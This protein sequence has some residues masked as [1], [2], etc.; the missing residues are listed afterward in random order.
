MDRTFFSSMRLTTCFLQAPADGGFSPPRPPSHS[1]HANTPSTLSTSPGESR[2]WSTVR[3]GAQGA[4]DE[5]PSLKRARTGGGLQP[6]PVPPPSGFSLPQGE[7]D[8]Q[9]PRGSTNVESAGGS[10]KGAHGHARRISRS[11]EGNGSPAHKKASENAGEMLGW[12]IW[13]PSR[14][15]NML[16]LV[17][18]SSFCGASV[19]RRQKA[20]TLPAN[21]ASPYVPLL[22]TA[23]PL[24]I[25]PI[26]MDAAGTHRPFDQPGQEWHQPDLSKR[27][28]KPMAST[29]SNPPTGSEGAFA[30]PQA[31]VSLAQRAEFSPPSGGRSG[32]GGG[33]VA[34]SGASKTIQ[35]Y[36]FK[37]PNSTAVQNLAA[38]YG[39]SEPA[40]QT[41][42]AS[43]LPKEVDLSGADG[44][45]CRGEANIAQPI[46][47][48]SRSASTGTGGT[49]G[50]SGGRSLQNRFSHAAQAAEDQGACQAQRGQMQAQRQGQALG[51]AGDGGGTASGANDVRARSERDS[52]EKLHERLGEA[53]LLDAQLRKELAR[54]N[55]ERA[56]METMVS[57]AVC[58]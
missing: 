33:Q 11:A 2:D 57:S 22:V 47:R 45:S 15:I 28:V 56:S 40:A 7:R 10:T 27:S 1:Q 4:G 49:G 41:R 52:V 43:G 50:E 32:K 14:C 20:H 34:P 8:H 58:D 21:K 5:V 3:Q 12:L 42:A 51:P 55:L 37:P 48:I 53:K 44:D 6:P 13:T 23:H 18:I 16:M 26:L 9:A 24:P 36:F 31:A 30:Q 54:A 25:P 39:T 38:S 19:L 46:A 17:D 35:S 29:L